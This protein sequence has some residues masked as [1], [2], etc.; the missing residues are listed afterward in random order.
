MKTL[1]FGAGGQVGRELSR[2]A[3]ERG[4]LMIPCLRD[5]ADLATPGAA[6]RIVRDVA[7]DAVVNAAAH[8]AV[9]KAES[10]PDLA[11]RLNAEAPGEIAVAAAD[12]G[13]AFVHISTDYVFD[14]AGDGPLDEDAPT[15]PLNVY[16]LTKRDGEAAALAA[17]G[18]CAVLRTSWVYGVHGGNFVKTMLRLGATRDA[19]AVVADQIGG[20]TP[21]GAIA[22]A[23]LAIAGRLR[24]EPS[25]SGLYHFQGAP[26]TSWADFARAIFAVSGHSVAVSDIATADYP[27][28]ARRP[29]N[30]VL[31]CGKIS[32]AFGIA[33][34][35]W[36]A[37]L[38]RAVPAIM[39]AGD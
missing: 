26:A 21:A 17:G 12:V 25:A 10:A 34:P 16:G 5:Q 38:A 35:D 18:A 8:T 11:R 29:L 32:R 23:C 4:V 28:P 33:Q 7:P 6:A 1:V 3:R 30:T 14:G 39:A 19:L 37:D 36:R 15:G 31:D 22:G 2:A 27:T 24:A 13:A 20:P 9:D